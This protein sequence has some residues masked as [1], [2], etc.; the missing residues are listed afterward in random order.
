MLVF[1]KDTD[2]ADQQMVAVIYYLVTFGYI[3]G[4]FDIT[5]QVFI[6]EHIRKLVGWRIDDLRIADP[7]IRMEVTD[8]TTARFE[9]VYEQ[10]NAEVKGLFDEV[11]SRGEDPK[12]YIHA[13]LKVRCYELLRQF[14]TSNQAILL[15]I[16][17]KLTIADGVT[18]EAEQALRAE[19]VD[20]LAMRTPPD[21][22]TR[23]IGR[24]LDVTAAVAPTAPMDDQP[25]LARLEKHS[26]RDPV[27]RGRQLI[28]DYALL[29]QTV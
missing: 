24:A 20:L 19:L 17:D 8:R 10:V 14:D 21:N 15:H 6:R 3:D 7:R 25:R 28:G 23:D 13:R 18:H 4:R 2:V 9:Q 26:S 11:T 1:S 27:K 5:E 12:A 22:A 29:T 16:I